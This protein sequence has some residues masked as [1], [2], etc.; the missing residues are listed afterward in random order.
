MESPKR[1]EAK[2][3]FRL[4]GEERVLRSL[5]GKMILTKIKPLGGACRGAWRQEE[6]ESRPAPARVAKP[7]GQGHLD[8][9]PMLQRDSR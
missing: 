2:E 9:D 3:A 6:E 7:W 5:P 4:D 1:F 8:A